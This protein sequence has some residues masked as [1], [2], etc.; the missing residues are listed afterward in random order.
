MPIV[1]H[2]T[3][4]LWPCQSKWSFIDLTRLFLRLLGLDNN[5]FFFIF[6]D[7][8]EIDEEGDDYDSDD[9]TPNQELIASALPRHF[10]LKLLICLLH[11]V[12]RAT[13]VFINDLHLLALQPR[14]V[15][16]VVRQ[17]INVLHDAGKHR[18][19]IVAVLNHVSHLVCHGL[20]VN[21]ALRKK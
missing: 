19:L 21:P 18:D 9:D 3:N 15:P 12:S 16:D 4:L 8:A 6:V 10:L 17:F 5:N 7:E 11:I 1:L 2:Q 14:L 20:L 13:Q